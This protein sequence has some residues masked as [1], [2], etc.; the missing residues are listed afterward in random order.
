MTQRNLGNEIF[1]RTSWGK[2]QLKAQFDLDIVKSNISSVDAAKALLDKKI[3]EVG[4]TASLTIVNS[5]INHA[6]SIQST[7]GYVGYLF[8]LQTVWTEY[9]VPLEYDGGQGEFKYVK[10]LINRM[11]KECA[12]GTVIGKKQVIEA[13]LRHSLELLDH[14]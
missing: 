8:M 5:I 14:V 10:W 2:K 6:S 4:F 12:E 7:Y 3:Q 9:G 11:K 1:E 13:V